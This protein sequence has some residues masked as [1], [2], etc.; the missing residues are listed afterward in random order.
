MRCA[1]QLGGRLVAD[2]AKLMAAGWHPDPATEVAI[3]DMARAWAA[4][5]PI[6]ADPVGSVWPF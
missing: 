5:A 3:A 2:P 1:A 6:V 4:R